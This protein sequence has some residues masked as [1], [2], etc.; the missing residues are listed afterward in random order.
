MMTDLRQRRK[1]DQSSKSVPNTSE[2]PKSSG[3]KIIGQ[4]VIIFG[5]LIVCC[6]VLYTVVNQLKSLLLY[7]N[8]SEDRYYPAEILHLFRKHDRDS[9]NYL[10][11]EEFEP[12]A[13]QFKNRKVSADYIEPI[14]NA[15]QIVT[16][17]AFFEPVNFSTMTT[18]YRYAYLVCCL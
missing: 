3:Y 7:N 13:N 1:E 5:F 9:D 16:I 4:N 2:T 17:D 15:D 8:D 11:I 14:L 6:F 10:S 18:Q 12:I